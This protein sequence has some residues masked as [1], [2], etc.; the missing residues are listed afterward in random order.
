MK[1]FSLC[2]RASL[3]SLLAATAQ[4]TPKIQFDTNLFDFGHL[5][6]IQY[7]TGSFKFKNVGDTDLKVEPPK[8]SCGCTDAKVVPDTLA[9]GQSGEVTYRINLEHRMVKNFKTIAINSND[10]RTPTVTLKAQLEFEPVYDIDAKKVM[11][12]VPIGKDEGSESFSVTR[13]DEHPLGIDRIV[14]SHDFITASVEA[15]PA[16]NTG[17]IVVTLKRVPN[18]PARF[19]GWLKLYNSQFS[20]DVPV[21]TIGVIGAIEGELA[22]SPRGL[23]WMFSDQGTDLSKYPATALSR[24]VQLKSVLGHD[25]QIK[26]AKCSIKGTSVQIVPKDPGKTFDLVLKLDE[27]PRGFVNGKVTLETSL[28]SLPTMEVPVTISVFKP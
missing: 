2:I 5:D 16:D 17:Q 6:G 4:A 26:S 13:P 12:T 21:R 22:A 10:P 1:T 28:A 19:E 3:I 25:V 8:P 7:V 18:A 14:S 11:V 9:P 15:K 27:V 20:K 24:S 23:Y